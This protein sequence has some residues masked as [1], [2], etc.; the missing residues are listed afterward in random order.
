MKKKQILL[1]LLLFLVSFGSTSLITII[2]ISTKVEKESLLIHQP[3]PLPTL[4]YGAASNPTTIDPVDCWDIP[5]ANVIFQVCE[6]LVTN[7]LSDSNYGIIPM[8]AEAWHWHS[9]TEISF[10]LRQGVLFHDGSPFTASSV[11]W[12]LDRITWFCNY[13]GTLQDN[14]TS[15]LAFP[16]SLYYFPDGVTPIISNYY[17]NSQYNITIELTEHFAP[18]L[19]LLTTTSSV[20]VS[21][22]S[23]PRWT[24]LDLMTGD[25]VGTGPFLYEYFYYDNEVRF[26]VYSDY[27]QG[28]ADIELLIFAIEENSDIRNIMLLAHEFDFIDSVLPSYHS[29]IIADPEL[30]LSG[31][32]EELCYFY[33][34]FYCGDPT[35]PGLNVTWR[36]AL[37]HAINYS[38]II[39]DLYQGVV[40]RAPPA[41]PR[42]LPGYNSSVQIV[43]M[44]ITKARNLIMTMFPTETTG[45]DPNFPG[46][47][48]LGW[49]TLAATTPLRTVQ[50]NRHYGHTSN[51]R[52][53]ENM[54]ETFSLIGVDT[55]ETIRFWSEYLDTGENHPWDM[56]ISY[57]G[58]CCDYLDAYNILGPLF[59]NTSEANFANVND[60]YLES[61]LEQSLIEHDATTRQQIYMHIQSY[62]FEVNTPMHEWKY[63]QAPLFISYGYYAHHIDVMGFQY[64]P[65]NIV[66]FYPCE[67]PIPPPSPP[68][69]F[70]LISDADN[71]DIDGNCNLS[72]TA[73]IG[74]VNYSVYSFNHIITE[75]NGS[76]DN[77]AYQTALSPYPVTGLTEGDHYFIAV[78]HNN[79]GDTLSNCYKITVEFEEEP[80]EIIFGYNIILLCVLIGIISLIGI[81]SH[82]KKIK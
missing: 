37:Q 36:K 56:E 49:T 28:E 43:D 17:L 60:P 15:W 64:D 10:K 11:I 81:Y 19:D 51:M 50:L 16:S 8:L 58:W 71:P 65:R 35:H 32:F 55:L 27:W 72:W 57:I 21:P 24:Y 9:P 80:A 69:S 45:L 29:Q 78:A 34:E 67:L 20:I 26:D 52:M 79:A 3:P 18:F 70:I 47:T 44:N 53:N 75:I 66:Y 30:I 1:L 41:V 23:T 5:S 33:L 59:G 76:L 77:L 40:G 74:A 39:D 63:P 42:M 13:T 14:A 2:N 38:Y 25:L 4:I 22:S 61:L 68:G 62:L 31:P 54:N 12:N 7:N 6:G 73:S 82:Q 48:E 46:T